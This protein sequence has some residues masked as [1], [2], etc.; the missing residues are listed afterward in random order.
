MNQLKLL[1]CIFICFWVLFLGAM[2]LA[3]GY[4]AK[5]VPDDDG[6]WNESLAKECIATK[7]E[8]G[9]PEDFA[10]K[11]CKDISWG[12]ARGRVYEE[13]CDP[14]VKCCFVTIEED[15]KWNYLEYDK[16]GN[17]IKK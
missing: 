16:N 3:F 6:E 2:I 14:E 12:C 9:Y 11:Y 10:E 13:N 8:K 5:N 7:I 15:K 4:M 1:K 17:K